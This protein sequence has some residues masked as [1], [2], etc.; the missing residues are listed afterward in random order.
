MVGVGVVEQA[1]V[2]PG[3][4][5]RKKKKERQTRRKRKK[6]RKEEEKRANPDAKLQVG[7]VV[8]GLLVVVCVVGLLSGGQ[9][10]GVGEAQTD[11]W[12]SNEERNLPPQVV[13]A[14]I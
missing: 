6:K 8:D 5:L 2:A 4:A 12:D 10:K 11:G 9:G 14:C 13:G 1:V 7:A 3:E